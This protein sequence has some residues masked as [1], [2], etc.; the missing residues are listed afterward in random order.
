MNELPPVADLPEQEALPDPFTM[1]DGTP[2]TTAEDWREKRRPELVQLFQHY[3]YGFAP[4]AE[5]E[6]REDAPE[7]EAF[8]GTARVKQIEIRIKGLPEDAPRI[9]LA[10][11]VPN[12]P[13]P[14]PVMLGIKRV[15]NHAT[16]GAEALLQ[17]EDAYIP[18]ASRKDGASERGGRSDFWC[19]EYI[20]SR[21]Y[22]FATFLESDVDPD[23]NDFTNGIHPWY[24]DLPYPKDA[25]WA[26]IRAWAWGFRRCVDYLVTDPDIDAGKI[27]VIGHSRRGKT[28][29]LAAALDE[30]IALA[31]PHQSG[32][33]GCAIS[34]ASEQ[35]TVE[36]INRVFPHWF[37]GN[38]K[39]FNDNEARL[40]FDQHLLIALV[41]PRALLD[42]EGKQDAWAN[43]PAS[44]RAL[45]AA[46]PVWKLL[47]APGIEGPARVEDVN[48]IQPGKVGN[49]LQLRLDTKHDLTRDYWV[50]IL[51]FA[52]AVYGR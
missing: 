7:A 20:L 4:E 51:N 37:N 49:L 12:T 30:R 38:F 19:V 5:S 48:D 39:Q 8:D 6:F 28:A 35:E 31:V 34:R 3:M 26:T 44:L 50:G 24:P 14:H 11:I 1:M 40:P 2:V 23:E 13:G 33:G 22:A 16:C 36:R 17:R 45:G 21:G 46:D 32:T 52:D 42:T 43:N 41:A 15:G 10:V 25:Q 27:G 18:E 29:L 47:G 9:H